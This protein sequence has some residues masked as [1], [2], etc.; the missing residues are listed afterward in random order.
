MSRIKT[1]LSI[2]QTLFTLAFLVFFFTLLNGYVLNLVGGYQANPW[3]VLAGL[4]VELILTLVAARSLISVQFDLTECVGFGAVVIGVWLYFVAASLPTLLPP[5]QSVDAVR[6]YLQALFSYPKGTL[7]SWYPAGGAFVVATFSHWVGVSPLRVLHPTAAS[8]IALSAGAVYGITCA[9]FPPKRLSKIAALFAPVLLFVPWSYFAGAINWEQYF[10]AQVFAQFFV[11]AALWYIASYAETS[12]WMFLVLLGAAL[13]GI[14]AAYPYLVALPIV[15]FGLVLVARLRP[16]PGPSLKGKGIMALVIFAVLMVFAAVALQ[17]GGILELKTFKIATEGDVGEG[18]VTNPS[19]EN[20]G[21]PIFLLLALVGIPLAWRADARGRTILAFV[22]AWFLQ[23]GALFVIQPILQ[24]SGYRV[25]KTFYMLVYPLAILA[26]LAPAWAINRWLTRIENSARSLAAAFL[27]VIVIAS[28]GVLAF[29]PPIAFSPFTESELETALWAKEHLDTYQISY[30]EPQTVRAYWLAFGLWRENLPNE[31][32][33]WIPAGVKLGPKT[34]DEWLRDPAWPRWLLVPDVTQVR[35]PLPKI[36]YQSGNSAILEKQ[37][38]PAAAPAPAIPASLYFGSTLKLLGYDLSRTTFAPG[39][40]ITVTTYTES[41]Y[42]PLATIG[43][44]VELQDR[45]GNVVSKASGDPF[46]S[47]YPLQRWSPG[48]FA[49]DTWSLP[50]DPNLAPGIYKLQLGLYRRVDGEFVDVHTLPS[51][52]DAQDHFVAASLAKIKIPVAPPSSDELAAAIPLNA[53]FGDNVTLVSYTLRFDRAARR[54]H[55]T[56]FWQSLAKSET[57]YTIFVHL[58]DSGGKIIAQKDAPP[59]DGNYPTSA[60]DAGEIV[61]DEYDL[62]IPADAP[63]PSSIEIGM[64]SQ[65]SMQ[66][67]PVGTDDKITLD[68]GL[69]SVP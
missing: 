61:K 63:M 68:L 3:L 44:R 64:Y 58:M 37:V 29:R 5:T 62:A 15:A 19:L 20:L 53:R 22:V 6:H 27:T 43:W 2:S 39:E 34:F 57:D 16:T 12:N 66:R 51:E 25:D 54:A 59:R 46:G 18:G 9:L 60:W 55:L 13:L 40:T 50:L 47:K 35:A 36:V 65:P 7:V 1:Q 33:Q 23:L 14:V 69:R 42:P 30:L 56:L 32:F 4:L 17:H 49:R 28:V 31:W 26:A 10:F 45:N 38:L 67:L 21:G 8:V 52:L 48:Q 11:V 24:I 41:L